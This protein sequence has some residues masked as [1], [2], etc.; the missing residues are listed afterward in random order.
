MWEEGDEWSLDV[1][2]ARAVLA[3]VSRRAHLCPNRACRRRRLCLGR[4]PTDGPIVHGPLGDCPNMSEAEWQIVFLGM[5]R[6]MK[7][8]ERYYRARDTAFDAAI[9]ALPK[10][11]R[12]ELRADIAAVKEKMEAEAAKRPPPRV[13]YFEFLWQEDQGWHLAARKDVREAYAEAIAWGKK[14]GMVKGGIV[15]GE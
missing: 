13:S 11:E 4:F 10:K 6:V 2:R 15:R 14:R 12:D 1:M 3:L 8:F 5:K 7:R 9:D